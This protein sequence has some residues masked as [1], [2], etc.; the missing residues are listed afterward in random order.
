[1]VTCVD[2]S[3]DPSIADEL[4]LDRARRGDSDALAGL[5]VI[6]QPQVLRLL[7]SRG[8]SAAEDI[9]S[10]VWIDVGRSLDRFEGDG[11]AFRN[12]IFTIAQRRAIDEGRRIARRHEI[13]VETMSPRVMASR[14][15]DPLGDSLDGV[16]ALLATLQPAAAE[17][18][19]LRVVHDLPVAEVATITGH[20]ESNVRVLAHRALERLRSTI[21]ERDSIAAACS[22]A[23][24]IA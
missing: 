21:E 5:W 15:L 13:V 17:V 1:M 19:M 12:W 22:P 16:F 24:R 3:A 23:L 7:R 10:Q 4:T 18:V 9:A 11:V 2:T 14:A 20:S 8:R 6:Y